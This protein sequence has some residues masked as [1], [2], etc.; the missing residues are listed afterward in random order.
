[1]SAG[2]KKIS[3]FLVLALFCDQSE[4]TKTC[5]EFLNRAERESFRLALNQVRSVLTSPRQR[6]LDLLIVSSAE[7]S[8]TQIGVQLNLSASVVAQGKSEIVSLAE[9]FE[10]VLLRY[11]Q[12][13]RELVKAL[14]MP[15][16]VGPFEAL[17]H[18]RLDP[19]DFRQLGYP[20]QRTAREAMDRLLSIVRLVILFRETPVEDYDRV[21]SRITAFFDLLDRDRDPSLKNRRD[22]ERNLVTRLFGFLKANGDPQGALSF[23]ANIRYKESSSSYRGAPGN[24]YLAAISWLTGGLKSVRRAREESSLEPTPAPD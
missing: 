1:M 6:I 19:I 4:A 16:D 21:E 22:Q 23:A 11:K 3:W 14:L 12:E 10:A 15:F 13:Y 24:R 8:L 2:F 20:T 18:R 5:K 9:E 17:F 7:Q